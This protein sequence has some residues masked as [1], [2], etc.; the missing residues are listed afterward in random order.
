MFL[1][2]L[3]IRGINLKLFTAFQVNNVLRLETSEF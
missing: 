1:S 3:G 2:S